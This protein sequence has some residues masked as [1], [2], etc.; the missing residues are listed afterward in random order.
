MDAGRPLD[1]HADARWQPARR[2]LDQL[3]SLGM[4]GAAMV[5]PGSWAAGLKEYGR[6]QRGGK[7]YDHP[8]VNGLYPRMQSLWHD[9]GVTVAN[10]LGDMPAF[11]SALLDTEVRDH[12]QLSFSDIDKQAYH[13]FSGQDIPENTSSVYGVNYRSLRG[14]P[15]DR[16]IPDNFSLLDYYRWFWKQGDGWNGLFT[17]ENNGL[18]SM[19]GSKV[20]TWFDPAIRVPS[21]WGSGGNVDYLSQW[22]YSYPAPLKI[23]M[24]CNELEA[25]AQ[26]QSNQQIMHMIQAIWYRS[27]TA[28]EPK[29]G[30]K[31]PVTPQ[32]KW[33]KE[34]PD[35]HFISIAPDHLSEGMWL[36]LSYPVKGIMIHG[37]GALVK[38][39][40]EPVYRMTNP[41]TKV[42]LTKLLHEV[43]QPLGPTLMQVPDIQS[44][45]AYLESFTSQIL[46]GRGTYG[47][48][49]SDS[50]L[51]LR[52]AAI[53]P[54]VIYEETIL[55]HGLKP[56]KVL[57]LAHCDVLPQSVATAIKEFQLSGGIIIGDASLAPGIQADI[58]MPAVPNTKRAD[59]YKAG[60]MAAAAKLRAELDPYYA[61]PLDSSNPEVLVRRRR[62]NTSD[63]IFAVNDHRTFGNYVGQY[64]LVMEEG[65]PSQATLKLKRNNGYIYDLSKSTPVTNVRRDK[66]YLSFDSHF[67]PGQGRLFLITSHAVSAVEIKAPHQA[68]AGQAIVCDVTVAGEAGQAIDAVVPVQIQI[69]DGNG[70]E[71]E[72]SGYYGAKGGM[73]ELKLD[74][75]R[76]AVG[77]WKIRARELASGLTQEAEFKVTQ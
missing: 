26:G 41:Q 57:V 27:E 20:W 16:I 19:T 43:V 62:Y 7:P 48:N 23:D 69:I 72:F 54:Q 77:T 1:M 66:G 73:V 25:M 14:F 29:A 28:P 71:A 65:V 63:Y 15:S 50:Y 3:L 35:A 24:A 76:T 12:T 47:W 40:N 45:V 55:K 30:Q 11:Q 21:I 31:K 60:I 22:T 56:Y 64:G 67:G 39:T 74:L 46:A 34:Q 75:P 58:L 33:E 36:E 37:W 10:S 5:E 13:R 70:R 32:A 9:I 53:Q 61:R 68:A 44:D 6:R 59:A 2:R 42:R 4:S 49:V 17:Q 51:T 18:H 38:E 52:H 8:N